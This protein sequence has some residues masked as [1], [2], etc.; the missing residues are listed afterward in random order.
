[1]RW[2]MSF[3]VSDVLGEKVY[4]A[5]RVQWEWLEEKEVRVSCLISQGTIVENREVR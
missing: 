2:A 1:M 4:A 5:A 3:G